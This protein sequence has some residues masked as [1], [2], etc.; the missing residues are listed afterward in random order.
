MDVSNTMTNPALVESTETRSA[1]EWKAIEEWLAEYCR[2]T[3]AYRV[4]DTE[5][6][7]KA[8]LDEEDW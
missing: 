1:D 7:L 3:P 4:I 6:D 5:E 2:R 8:W